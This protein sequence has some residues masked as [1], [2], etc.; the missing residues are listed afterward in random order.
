MSVDTLLRKEKDGSFYKQSSEHEEKSKA[1]A[2]AY[3]ESLG[4][5]KSL[6]G[7]TKVRAGLGAVA[8]SSLAPLPLT[9]VIDA[10]AAGGATARGKELTKKL[11]EAHPDVIH[12]TMRSLPPSGS[13][14]GHVG[15]QPMVFTGPTASPSLVAH[16]LGHHEFGKGR[17]GKIVQNKIHRAMRGE[18]G[19]AATT[20]GSLGVG[21]AS[22]GIEGPAGTALAVGTPFA[23]NAPTLLTEGAASVKGLQ[24]LAR[25]GA[26]KKELLKATGQLLPA[27]GTYLARPATLAGGSYLTRRLVQADK[28]GRE[29]SEAAA[30]TKESAAIGVEMQNGQK[31]V[32]SEPEA[33][34]KVKKTT[35]N[36]NEFMKSIN[37][38]LLMGTPKMAAAYW[39]EKE[40]AGTA[41]TYLPWYGTALGGTGGALLGSKLVPGKYKTLATLGGTLAGTALGLHGGEAV[42]KAI[43]KRRAVDAPKVAAARQWSEYGYTEGERSSQNV[44]VLGKRKAGDAPTADGSENYYA[45]RM[46]PTWQP[47]E[48]AIA[49]KTAALHPLVTSTTDTHPDRGEDGAPIRMYR[50][51]DELQ[52]YGPTSSPRNLEGEYPDVTKVAFAYLLELEMDK[53]A[54][55]PNL[56]EMEKEAILKQLRQAGRTAQE[57]GRAL[58]GAPVKLQVGD[59]IVQVAGNRALP[60]M[61]SY[62]GAGEALSETG[63]FLRLPKG[64]TPEQA[65]ELGIRTSA[66]SR[67]AGEALTSAGHHTEH[68]TTLG[69]VLNPLGK[70]VG[71]AFEGISRGVGKELERASGAIQTGIKGG[72]TLGGGIA[73]SIGRGLQRHAP[74]V[75]QAG[76]ILGAAGTATAAG[77]ALSPA[78]GALGSLLKST[79]VYAPLKAQL[80]AGGLN[81]AKD[82]A[83]TGVEHGLHRGAKVLPRVVSAVRGAAG[84]LPKVLTAAA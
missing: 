21:A 70:P 73:G 74:R 3:D 33:E 38:Y 8:G 62:K 63:K 6:L 11:L 12:D 75:G 84:H 37:D 40:A 57:V 9:R 19:S 44:P 39:M 30:Q 31:R 41:E 60:R 17:I 71:G 77:A 34:A 51:R 79:G 61:P 67:I 29:A 7:D 59:E 72:E 25:A 24:Q 54:N 15:T 76:E 82:V 56:S 55:D 81:L 78:A 1:Y 27:F 45:S 23:L 22:A 4:I 13:A 53:V 14:Y 5:D 69:K 65:K 64:M 80:G 35:Q 50:A 18:L 36:L 68:A 32:L 48:T 42:G 2:K 16:E 20:L 26:S 52:V 28:K 47:P 43:D 10:T 49:P 46:N 66:G 58:V 83:A